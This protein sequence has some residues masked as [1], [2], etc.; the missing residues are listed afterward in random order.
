MKI[1]VT[2]VQTERRKFFDDEKQQ[3]VEYEATD[4]IKG[5]WVSVG[6]HG[7]EEFTNNIVRFFPNAVVKIHIENEKEAE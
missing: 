2:V 7:L 1:K 5:E 6:W 4:E 3:T